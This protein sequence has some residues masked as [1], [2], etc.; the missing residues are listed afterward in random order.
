MPSRLVAD[1]IESINAEFI[2]SPVAPHGGLRT[3]HQR[4]TCLE[5]VNFTAFPVQIWSRYPP[6]FRRRETLVVHGV[7]NHAGVAPE[8]APT[9]TNPHQMVDFKI[10]DQMV[11]FKMDQMV[12][13]KIE[14]VP[15]QVM[16]QNLGYESYF[17]VCAQI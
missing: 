17:K 9:T 16:S 10:E 5:A 7:V 2:H 14:F 4:S 6:E 13:F 11:D 12:D 3:F 15:R 1:I 8:N